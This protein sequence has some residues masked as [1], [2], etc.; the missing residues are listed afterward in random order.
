MMKLEERCGRDSVEDLALD[1]SLALNL[2]DRVLM[3]IL[4]FINSFNDVIFFRAS[5]HLRTR[6][7]VAAAQQSLFVR[8][9]FKLMLTAI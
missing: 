4:V 8:L 1:M 2:Y 9:L 5:F 3:F 6:A 7:L